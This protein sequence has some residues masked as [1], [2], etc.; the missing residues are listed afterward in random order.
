[1]T[2]KIKT[3]NSKIKLNQEIK[4]IINK[5]KVIIKIKYQMKNKMN[6]QNYKMIN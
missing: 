3:N 1:M 2:M 4:I 5:I 6:F